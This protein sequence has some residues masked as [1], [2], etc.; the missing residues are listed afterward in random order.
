MYV[1][2]YTDVYVDFNPRPITSSI[3]YTCIFHLEYFYLCRVSHLTFLPWNI[4]LFFL[5]FFVSF[6]LTEKPKLSSLVNAST[7]AE[8]ILYESIKLFINVLTEISLK[9]SIFRWSILFVN[10][11]EIRSYRSYN[12]VLCQS[13]GYLEKTKRNVLGKRVGWLGSNIHRVRFLQRWQGVMYP[14]ANRHSKVCI[15]I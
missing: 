15:M 14:T 4:S 7:F 12:V 9:S 6:P 8:S 3:I 1:H 13:F 11:F 10:F 5:F 2:I